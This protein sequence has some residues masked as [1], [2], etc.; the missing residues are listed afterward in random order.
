MLLS[1]LVIKAVQIITRYEAHANKKSVRGSRGVAESSRI[2]AF[3]IEQGGAIPLRPSGPPNHSLFAKLTAIL[4]PM[5]ISL[6]QPAAIPR[7]GL[8]ASFVA[9]F[10]CMTSSSMHEIRI[11]LMLG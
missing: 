4:E 3:S 8:L 7:A 5:S 9:S 6:H 10:L 1:P 2:Y 11:F